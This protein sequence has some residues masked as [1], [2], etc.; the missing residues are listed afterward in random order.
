MEKQ[1][2]H[3]PH[4]EYPDAKRLVLDPDIGSC[5]I[6]GRALKARR[7]WHSRKTIQTLNGPLFVAGKTKECVNSA[8][9]N[10]QKRYYAGR[11]WLYSL[12]G[13]TYG[14]DVLAWIGWQHEHEHRQLVEIQHQLNQRGIAVNERNVGKLYRQFL[15][16]LSATSE[17]ARGS[18]EETVQEYGGLIWAVDALQP[19]GPCGWLYVLYE[20]LS[21]K[22]IAA[23]QGERIDQGDL[24]TWLRPY[25]TLQLPVL[26][27]LSDG[28]STIV[29]AF[30]ACWPEV[31]H[32]RCQAHFLNNLA[33]DVLDYDDELRKNMRQDLGGLPKVPTEQRPETDPPFSM[34]PTPAETANSSK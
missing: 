22:P 27:T 15:A 20:V 1:A 28:E 7:N 6:C 25:Q 24:E 32:Q 2:R 34:S 31:P 8:C 11:V 14:L 13:S 3:R 18:L 26:A 9:R 12:P 33:E 5:P 21:G 4:R 17:N 10:Y 23:L 19:E 16:L 29:A 30:K